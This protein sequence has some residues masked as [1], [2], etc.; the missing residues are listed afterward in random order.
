M[1]SNNMKTTSKIKNDFKMFYLFQK[2][3]SCFKNRKI[4]SWLQTKSMFNHNQQLLKISRVT[5]KAW[6]EK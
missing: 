6:E 3:L 1:I 5:L 4:K 2:I